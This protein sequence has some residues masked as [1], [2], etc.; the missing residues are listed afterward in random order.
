MASTTSHDVRF[1]ERFA[2]ARTAS[3]TVC[4][5]TAGPGAR[6]AA[7]L[8]AVREVADEIVVALDDRAAADVHEAVAAVADRVLL[9]PYAE[10]VDRPVP[11]LYTQCRGDWV[12]NLDDDEVPSPELVLA[13]P[14]LVAA[15]DVTHYWIPRRWLFPDLETFLDEAPWRP[16]YQ[17]RLL[18]N[19][20]RLLRF[21]ADLH[22]PLAVLGPGRFL[23]APVWH[24][25]CI[26]R[27]REAR[28]EKARKYERL[29]PGLRV[30][31]VALN[32]AYFLPE[33]RQNVRLG[34]VPPADGSAVERVMTAASP[35][36]GSA[37]EVTR[38]T[39]A[40]IDRLWP[41]REFGEDSYRARLELLEPPVRL[42]TGEQ[43][44]LDVRVSNHGD[45]T[46]SWGS[47]G[48]PAVRVASRWDGEATALRTP[49]PVDLRPGVSTVVPVH[50]RAP[51]VAGWYRLELDLVHEH[52]R[53]FECAIAADVEVVRRRRVAVVGGD[54]AAGPVLRLLE[55]R[56]DIEPI[57]VA[58][59]AELPWEPPGHPRVPGVR[60]Y[61][62]GG[63]PDQPGSLRLV[64]TVARRSIAL[65]R[66]RNLSP[67]AAAFVDTLA[68]SCALVV[69][70][71]DAPEGAPLPRE[72]ARIAAIA[73]AA[74]AAGVPV[75]VR[76][77]ALPSSPR[78]AVR[79]L[80]RLVVRRATLVYAEDGELD[81]IFAADVEA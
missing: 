52:V 16:D 18:R 51:A 65:A 60:S 5:M 76:R 28:E 50:V 8:A 4:C 11:W 62:F 45:E 71:L 77:D 40:E 22:R 80:T 12:L 6:V 24:L 48:E 13:L 75:A 66:G 46:W 69:A 19:D 15:E 70:G 36:A 29:R 10:P 7:V 33:L 37:R 63:K 61:L 1:H 56:P 41:G 9:Y 57:L 17:L 27:P 42:A 78:F 31:G 68:D 39:R 79:L 55:H 30:G 32:A 34:R 20:R 59:D 64:A 44:A 73:W 3:L 23:E 43:R 14:G 72:L 25:D 49:L 58:R 47:D 38:V 74:R 67:N 81:H 26:V 54:D 53:W 21:S 2:P 35:A